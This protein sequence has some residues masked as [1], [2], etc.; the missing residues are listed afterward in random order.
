MPDQ[1]SPGQPGEQPLRSPPPAALVSPNAARNALAAS[2][3]RKQV[4]KKTKASSAVAQNAL[5]RS[6]QR[7]KEKKVAAKSAAVKV[8]A[9]NALLGSARRRQEA[10]EKAAAE[11]AAADEEENYE[12][13]FQDE[14]IEEDTNEVVA[15][16]TIEGDHTVKS[17]TKNFSSAE[18]NSSLQL[19]SA[20]NDSLYIRP[21][22][23]L[24]NQFNTNSANFSSG[25]KAFLGQ[26]VYERL[27]SR[28]DGNHGN[29]S[30]GN[31]S[32]AGN[33]I[34]FEQAIKNFEEVA[35]SVG[36]EE[37]VDGEGNS[38]HQ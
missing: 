33:S 37:A 7:N 25:A 4:E 2:G 6:G 12:D 1:G 24:L 13:D 16:D 27:M 17:N 36:L 3:K 22:S 21:T 9:N 15:G 34:D 18:E 28:L 10:A 20:A 29:S 8:G 23:N 35:Y 5:A 26:S 38:R 14:D 31:S 32:S 19:S 30:V 11:A